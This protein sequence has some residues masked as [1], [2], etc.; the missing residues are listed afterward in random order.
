MLKSQNT[1]T[2]P[3]GAVLLRVHERLNNDGWIL[4]FFGFK[5]KGHRKA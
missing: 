3:E 4:V 1:P 2:Y 5:G